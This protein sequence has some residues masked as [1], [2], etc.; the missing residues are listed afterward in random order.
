MKNKLLET[1][2]AIGSYYGWRVD[3]FIGELDGNIWVEWH[4]GDLMEELEIAFIFDDDNGVIDGDI[5][6]DVDKAKIAVLKA[7]K[8]TR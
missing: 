4:K 5:Y 8:S 3:A 1:L 2:Q 7:I 6:T